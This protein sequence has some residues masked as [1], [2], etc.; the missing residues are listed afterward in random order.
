M[1]KKEHL[2]PEIRVLVLQH[3]PVLAASGGE[4]SPIPCV[5]FGGD[6]PDDDTAGESEPLF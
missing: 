6:E 2:Q 5:Q 4:K 3:E 1:A